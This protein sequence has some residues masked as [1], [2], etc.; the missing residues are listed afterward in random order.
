MIPLTKLSI[1]LLY[2]R[3]FE[4]AGR[5]FRIALYGLVGLILSYYTAALLATIFECTPV[6]KSWE[7]TVPGTCI[8]TV[9]FFFVNAGFNIATDVAIMLLP[10][11]II[12]A[13]HLPMRQRIILCFV[14]AVGT[15]AT[16]TSIVRIFALNVSIQS[17]DPSW[18]IGQSSLWSAAEMNTAIICACIPVLKAPLQALFPRLFSEATARTISPADYYGDYGPRSPVRSHP[19]RR[20]R[21][22]GHLGSVPMDTIGKRLNGGRER[23]SDASEDEMYILQGTDSNTCRAVQEG[24]GI[25]KSMDIEVTFEEQEGA[26]ETNSTCQSPS[27]PAIGAAL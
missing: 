10:V 9:T 11:P 8:D 4:R 19:S 21:F 24:C 6:R 3:L 23:A 15:I 16:A 1:C 22:S 5:S 14:F 12:K 17:T 2:R 20:S 18:E 27:G 25:I 7:K 26:K 13:L